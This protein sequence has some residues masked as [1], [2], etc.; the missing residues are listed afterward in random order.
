MLIINTRNAPFLLS[1]TAFTSKMQYFQN[2][3]DFMD[4]WEGGG[5]MTSKALDHLVVPCIARWL[6]ALMLIF[7]TQSAFVTQKMTCVRISQIFMDSWEGGGL[8]TSKALNH[9]IVPG[10]ARWLNALMLFP[11][12]Q[13]RKHYFLNFFDFYVF[14]GGWRGGGDAGQGFRAA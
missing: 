9:F 8:M 6:G 7:N 12:T 4:S 3:S 14:V 1:R 2:F 13:T 10:I 5:L 11:H